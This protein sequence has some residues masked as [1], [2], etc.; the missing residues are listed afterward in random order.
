[1]C[2][3][4]AVNRKEWKRIMKERTEHLITLANRKRNTVSGSKKEELFDCKDENLD[5]IST[6]QTKPEIKMTCL[7]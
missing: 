5:I 6:T 1:M 3:E 7:W 4:E 2:R